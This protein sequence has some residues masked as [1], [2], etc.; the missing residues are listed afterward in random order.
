MF[1]ALTYHYKVSVDC[2]MP[3]RYSRIMTPSAFR[4][5][6]Y[7]PCFLYTILSATGYNLPVKWRLDWR[8]KG[9]AS[10]IAQPK[11]EEDGAFCFPW[12]LSLAIIYQRFKDNQFFAVIILR[13]EMADS[14]TTQVDMETVVVAEGNGK[15]SSCL[16]IRST[17]NS[18]IW[19][20]LGEKLMSCLFPL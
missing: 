10:T 12:W 19:K 13:A 2:T 1:L 8:H 7:K 6:P 4:L 16:C 15:R 18:T 11:Q 3:W 20:C 14:G 17:N 9:S 5:L